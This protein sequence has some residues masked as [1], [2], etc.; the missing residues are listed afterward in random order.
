MGDVTV[1]I[2]VWYFTIARGRVEEI[3]IAFFDLLTCEYLEASQ[4]SQVLLQ[5]LTTLYGISDDG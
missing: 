2:W 4:A 5:L 3:G 1:F